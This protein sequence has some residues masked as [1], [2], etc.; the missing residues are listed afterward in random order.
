MNSL[1]S[2]KT[3][4]AQVV[5][6]ELRSIKSGDIRCA[7]MILKFSREAQMRIFA[8]ECLMEEQ[9]G[10]ETYKETIDY[11]YEQVK[12]IIAFISTTN[13]ISTSNCQ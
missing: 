11:L 7:N 9:N 5:L 4:L 6:C 12:E 3:R 1:D 10:Y 8:I 2:Y 13:C